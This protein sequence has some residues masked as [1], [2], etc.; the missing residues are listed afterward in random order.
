M[1]HRGRF[2]CRPVSQDHASR[3]VTLK[4]VQAARCARRKALRSAINQKI[5]RLADFLPEPPKPRCP[6]PPA[7]DAPRR[8]RLRLYREEE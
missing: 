8:P 2:L 5:A 3:T 4:D 7:P 6:T 1:F